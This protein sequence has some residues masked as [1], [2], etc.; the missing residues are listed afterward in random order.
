MDWQQ[1]E[2]NNL[3]KIIFE[4]AQKL[5]RDGKG[6]IFTRV[7]YPKRG[8]DFLISI[9]WPNGKIIRYSRE[10]F[11]QKNLIEIREYISRLAEENAN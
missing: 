10:E 9:E 3:R 1:N 5:E 4:S 7:T 6:K 2:D 8:E 11:V